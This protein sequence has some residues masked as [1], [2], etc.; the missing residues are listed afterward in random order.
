MT[1]VKLKNDLLS[2]VIDSKGAELQSVHDSQ[3]EYLWQADSMYWNRHAPILFPVVGKL[4]NDSFFYDEHKYSMSQHGFARD[5][6]FSLI[7]SSNTH[8]S[9]SLQYSEQTLKH[10]PFKFLLEISYALNNRTLSIQYRVKNIDT[11]SI[12][13]S[14]GGHPGFNVPLDKSE[15]FEDYHIEFIPH[16][17][18]KFI[19]VTKEVL[20]D[21][22]SAETK[23]LESLP[24]TRE[25]FK[26]GVLIFETKGQTHIRL[27]SNKMGHSV[28]LSYQNMP[29]LGIWSPADSEAPFVC[30][31]P[32]CG[33]ADLSSSK[34]KFTEKLGIN[35][36]S[37]NQVFSREHTITFD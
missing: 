14:I 9:F 19:P 27:V 36:L 24:L 1:K 21:I 16:K 28:S 20:L 37:I 13:F 33:V 23:Q 34:N 5:S 25:L 26:K 2:V 31:E 35:H 4:K 6:D 22:D 3:K 12:Y 18:R 11:K 17:K 29:Y 8:A 32:W 30:I 10:Y 15:T 7:S